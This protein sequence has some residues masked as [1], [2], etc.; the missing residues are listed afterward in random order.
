MIIGG[1]KTRIEGQS[2]D[3]G[4]II[5]TKILDALLILVIYISAVL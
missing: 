1:E 4:E 3:I 2:I 5:Y